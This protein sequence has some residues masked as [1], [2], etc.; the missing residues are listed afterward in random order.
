[1]FLRCTCES[2]VAKQEDLDGDGD[3]AMLFD[4][5]ES[6]TRSH[7]GSRRRSSS[8]I[9]HMSTKVKFDAKGKGKSTSTKTALLTCGIS[10]QCGCQEVSELRDKAGRP[11]RAYTKEGLFVHTSRYNPLTSGIEII[12]CNQYCHCAPS[13]RSLYSSCIN[14]VAQKPRRIPIQVFKTVQRGWGVR[15]F[16]QDLRTGMV[17]GCYTGELIHRSTAAKLLGEDKTYVFDLDGKDP[18]IDE[19]HGDGNRGENGFDVDEED[20]D[21][22]V[23]MYSIDAR[24]CGNW[25][26][27]LNHSC[28]PNL[29]V[30]TAVWDTI[31][32]QNI[33]HLVFFALDDIPRGEEMTVDYHAGRPLPKLEK[34]KTKGKR[35]SV[36][37][38]SKGA[39]SET[40]EGER[41][42]PWGTRECFCGS[43]RCRGWV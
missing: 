20:L 30:Y 23:Q 15:C 35:K 3:V 42:R 9:S 6:D 32:E 8:R 36:P 24:R 4:D 39:A 31:P 34:T 25:T 10:S 16:E 17:L 1:M 13:V 26:R 38:G 43:R 2:D 37:E 11:M 27:F 18:P 21:P 29:A 14:R 33:P 12:E 40:G 19:V 41:N 7:S 22:N 28:H 5:S